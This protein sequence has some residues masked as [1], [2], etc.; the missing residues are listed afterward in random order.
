VTEEA[1]KRLPFARAR[2][3]PEAGRWI[4]PLII[5]AMVVLTITFVNSLDP[6]ESEAAPPPPPRQPHHDHHHP[7]SRRDRVPGTLNAYET[8]LNAFL[9]D[10][11]NTNNDWRSPDHRRRDPRLLRGDPCRDRRVQLS[12][13]SAADV[14]ASLAEATS[15]WCW[16]SKSSLPPS[17]PSSPACGLRPGRASAGRGD[18]LRVPGGGGAR[19]PRCA[20]R[21]RRA[22]RRP[23]DGSTTSTTRAARSPP[24]ASPPPPLRPHRGHRLP[25]RPA[26]TP[27]AYRS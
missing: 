11:Q 26:A 25:R 4:L 9:G 21:P 6:A 7:P 24:P 18:R 15:S 10:V 27:G 17:T 14:P 13:A 8:Q 2:T 22:D 16:R 20:A 19:C 5:L 1:G 23:R 3:R 12:V